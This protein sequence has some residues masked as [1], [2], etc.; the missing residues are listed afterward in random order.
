MSHISNCDE[1]HSSGK[2][3]RNK[4]NRIYLSVFNKCYQAQRNL[5]TETHLV[6]VF[7]KGISLGFL[8]DTDNIFL[9]V[10]LTS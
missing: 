4:P 1:M 2:T 7:M 5:I 8:Q 3:C 9:P 6:S 10:G